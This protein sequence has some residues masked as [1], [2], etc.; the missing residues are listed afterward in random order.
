MATMRN[1]FLAIS[2]ERERS[3]DKAK[4]E[5][6][7]ERAQKVQEEEEEEDATLSDCEECQKLL[8]NLNLD[9]HPKLKKYLRKYESLSAVKLEGV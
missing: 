8:Q 7:Q 3:R 1:N 2:R 6:E 4:C 9:D 5:Q